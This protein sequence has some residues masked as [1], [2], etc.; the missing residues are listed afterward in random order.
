[1]HP[2]YGWVRK[3]IRPKRLEFRSHGSPTAPGQENKPQAGLTSSTPR[4]HLMDTDSAPPLGLALQRRIH[5]PGLRPR[6]RPATRGT[7][8][9]ALAAGLVV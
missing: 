8:G 7:P 9:L 4:R 6:Q 1:V 2:P 3:V 5:R